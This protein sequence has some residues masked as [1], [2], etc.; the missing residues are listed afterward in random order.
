MYTRFYEPQSGDISL[1]T[2]SVK[3]ISLPL[4]RSA[5]SLVSQE[6]SLFEGTIR[7]NI[8]FGIADPSTISE[9]QLHQICRQASIHDFIISLP[10]GYDTEIGAKGVALSGGQKQ[11]IA[12][13]RALIRN[14]RVLLLDEATSNLDAETERD[15]MSVLE[16]EKG[17]RTLVMVAHRM[18]TVKNADVIFVM[19]DGRNVESGSH[20]ELI[21]K[22]G[23]YFQMVSRNNYGIARS[24]RLIL[25]S[26]KLRLWINDRSPIVR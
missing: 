25:S 18:A 16:K 19:G 5:L 4:Y 14:P 11:R 24:Q 7:S 2:R 10:Q 26:A 21:G 8:L 22:R 9:S 20:E 13:A 23:L 6:S 17:K 1:D 3:D 12:I 15:V